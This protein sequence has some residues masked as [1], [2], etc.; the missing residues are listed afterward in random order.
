MRKGVCVGCTSMGRI[1]EEEATVSSWVEREMTETRFHSCLWGL[2][3]AGG[4][5]LV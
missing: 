5:D 4:I 2:F 3:L 1:A